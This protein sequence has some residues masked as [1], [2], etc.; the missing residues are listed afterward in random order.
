VSW[1]TAF[2]V[3]FSEFFLLCLVLGVLEHL[4]RK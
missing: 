2:T 1:A 3:V 4:R